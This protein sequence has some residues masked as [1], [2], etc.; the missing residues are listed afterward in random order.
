VRWS[1]NGSLVSQG[2]ELRIRADR[3]LAIAAGDGSAAAPLAPAPAPATD[4]A[5]PT[6]EPIEWRAI[7][8]GS[9]VAGCTEG[10]RLCD[11]NERPPQAVTLNAGFD[12]MAAEV[13]VDQYRAF[14]LASGRPVPRQPHES[15]SDHPV[16]N[17][18]WQEAAAFCE[19]AG[20]RLPTELEWEFAARGGPGGTRFTTGVQLIPDAMNGPGVRGRDRWGMSSPVRAFPPGAFG[21]YDM[22]G[23]VWEWTA[24][25]YREGERWSQ[26]PSADPAPDSD[27]YR[28]TIRGGSWDSSERN[29]RVSVRLGLSVRGRHNLYVGFRCAR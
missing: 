9:F 15:A 13:T 24:S 4:R 26:P 17:L 25:W 27:D 6:R 11:D 1:V 23:N 28:R 29:L 14:A 2:Q 19:A 18:T 7:P 16:V 8:A 22:T 10:D 3:P 5:A 12:L 21:L 20:G